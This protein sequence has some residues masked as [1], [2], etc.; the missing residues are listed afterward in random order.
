[1]L[2]LVYLIWK[3]F[4]GEPHAEVVDEL[5][6]ELTMEELKEAFRLFDDTGDGFISVARF[7]VGTF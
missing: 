5:C 7:R 3:R 4:S 2:V 1:M 6:A